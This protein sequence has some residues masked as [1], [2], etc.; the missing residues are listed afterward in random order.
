M[1]S[2]LLLLAATVSMVIPSGAAKA[3]PPVYEPHVVPGVSTI[4]PAGKC[5]A[6]NLFEAGK[7]NG[8]GTRWDQ[9]GAYASCERLKVVFGPIWAKPGQNDVLIQPVTFEK[10]M[11]AGYLVR[12]KPDLVNSDGVSPRVKDVHLHHGTWLNP[13]YLGGDPFKGQAVDPVRQYGNG[14]WIASGE[15]KTIAVWPRGYGLKIEA[16]DQWL[17]LHMIHNATPQTFPVWVTYDLD[18]IPAAAAEANDPATGKPYI[19]NTSGLWLDV[20]DCSWSSQCKKDQFNPIFN[21]QRGFGNGGTCVFPNSNC[22]NENTLATPSAQQGVALNNIVDDQVTVPTDGSLVVMGGHV[23]FGGLADRVSLERDLNHDGAIQPNEVKLIHVSD[24]LYWD[25]NFNPAN[26]KPAD[27]WDLSKNVVGGTPTSWDMVMTGVTKDLGWSVKVQKGDKLRI[28]GVYDSTVASWYEEMGIVMTWLAPGD[29]SGLDPF[30]PSVTIGQ[31]LNTRAINPPTSGGYQ[32]PGAEFGTCT[33]SATVLC[34]RGQATHARVP[35]S[36]DHWS[37]INGCPNTARAAVDGPTVTDIHMAGFTYGEADFATIPLTGIPVVAVGKPVTF[38]NADTA[39]YMWH[40]ITRCQNPCSGTTSASYPIPDGAYDDVIDPATGTDADGHT[41]AQL[42][43]GPNKYN[44]L[45][46][47]DPMD[48]DSGQIGIGTGANNKLSWTWTPTRP[49][50]YTFFCR[51]H[52]SMRG[53]I[54]VK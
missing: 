43:S 16:S 21:I 41:L 7:D 8:L 36:G 37:C 38:W 24:A 11:Y 19:R 42:L 32:L 15:E 39:D 50:T 46:G 49:G 30:D 35:T 54:R 47:S 22:A 14:P 34:V 3:T 44:P 9:S 10:P 27:D 48:F 13:S 40:T 53:A 45:N 12:F 33:P 17:F 29:D 26:W 18:Y 23:H 52:P 51:I 31:G 1:R 28:E 5:V 4:V 25:E 2:R 6:D 20:G